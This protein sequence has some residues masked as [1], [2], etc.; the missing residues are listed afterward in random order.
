MTMPVPRGSSK[1]ALVAAWQAVVFGLILVQQALGPHDNA[2][3]SEPARKLNPGWLP[4]AIAR[5]FLAMH[6]G[7]A[8]AQNTTSAWRVQAMTQ[9]A[10]VLSL[11]GR[12]VEVCSRPRARPVVRVWVV[13]DATAAAGFLTCSPL[14]RARTRACMVVRMFACA[15]CG[16]RGAP[17]DVYCT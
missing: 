9:P 13:T 11:V 6:V 4:F 10:A 16:V 1:G 5:P 8:C 3:S 12:G 15:Q 7:L 2:C 17:A 14:Q